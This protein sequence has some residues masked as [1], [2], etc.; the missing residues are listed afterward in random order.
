VLALTDHDDTSGCAE[1]A[2]AAGRLGLTLVPG[3]EVSVTWQSMTIHVVG[4]QVDPEAPALQAGLAG[5]REFRDW[6]AEEIGRRLAQRGIHGA[7]DGARALARGRIISR[8]HFA[9]YLVSRHCGADVREV[10]KHYLRRNKPGHVP[11]QWASLEAALGWIREAGGIAVLAHP[12][13]YDLTASKLRRLLGEFIECGGEAIEVVSGSHTPS[14]VQVMARHARNFK[15]LA[16][17]GSDYHGPENPWVEL[18][19]LQTL[20]EGLTPVWQRWQQSIPALG[21]A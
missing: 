6:R 5:L 20:P 9:H 8:T 11:G 4:L 1:A 12:A 16:S 10:F 2:E 18:G 17:M 15:L 21:A 13:R 7:Y 14:D 19:R 3:V